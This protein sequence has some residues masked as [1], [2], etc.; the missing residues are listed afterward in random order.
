M[1]PTAGLPRLSLWSLSES[2]LNED[3]M[4]SVSVASL[5]SPD[6]DSFVESTPGR[7]PG[8]ASA[9]GLIA[10][11][12]YGLEP[13]YLEARGDSGLLMG[14]L[15][16]LVF[17]PLRGPRELISLPFLDRAGILAAD[18]GTRSDLLHRALA[19]CRDRGLGA[20]ELR[21]S[22]PVD[23]FAAEPLADRVNLVMP[24]AASEDEQ[25]S[26]LRAKVRNQT[27]KAEREGLKLSDS[28]G[29]RLLHEFYAPFC[30][31]MR[32]LG[33]PVHPRRFFS[34]AAK[35][36]GERLRFVVTHHNG[37]P[38]GGL[39]AI[40]Y[41]GAVCVPWAST[42]R[43]E[44][45]RCPNNQIYWEALRWAVGQ[46]AG[47]FDFGRSPRGE[48]TYRFK[49]GWGAEE[50]PLYW[51]RIGPD[52]TAMERRSAGDNPFL[53]K[54]SEVWTRLPTSVASALGPRL[55]RYLSN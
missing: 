31:N 5:P 32:D 14:V 34:A 13:L 43:T 23:G 40:H 2:V 20:L 8:H 37:R 9:W 1:G 49:T 19:I 22:Q 25:W 54:L 27:R 33:S 55:R 30:A 12:A 26:A 39:V 53:R 10:K 3:A 6:W 17:K 28:Q 16:L 11:D 29:D 38:V 52:G 35:H 41:A 15:S 46:G 47:C 51:V 36:F 44:R 21:A 45:A 50:E 42:L 4:T 24:L 7:H 18:A 48:G